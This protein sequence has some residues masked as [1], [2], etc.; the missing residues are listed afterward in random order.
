MRVLHVD[1]SLRSTG[2]VSREMSQTFI[3]H[4][5]AKKDI[6]VDRLDLETERF[7]HITQLYTDALYAMPGDYTS[8][9]EKE[10]EISNGLVDRIMEAELM[11]IGT[12]TYNFGI[13]SSLKT[14][15]DLTVRSGRTF[16]YTEAGFEG[17]LRGKKVVVIN[18][19]G[20]SY[21]EEE[22]MSNDHVTGYLTTILDF[23]GITDL[24]FVYLDPTFFGE[25]ATNTAKAR[26][27]ERFQSIIK[28]L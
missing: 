27:E 13:P 16:M 4:L 28:N 9:Q 12:P 7:D 14:F 8:E 23:I 25:D 6:V 17:L 18:S 26:A 3:D 10:L 19:R 5:K 22:T 2:S 20:L 15:I 21:A 11:V 1:A 24:Q